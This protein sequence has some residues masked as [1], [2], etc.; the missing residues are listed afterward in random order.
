VNLT[1]SRRSLHATRSLAVGHIVTAADIAV[2]R[3]SRGLSPSL[4]D[5]LI[6]TVLTRAI[7]EGAPFLGYDLPS[8]RSHSGVA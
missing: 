4:F 1:A 7:D 6:G 2:L 3:P 8:S 5:E